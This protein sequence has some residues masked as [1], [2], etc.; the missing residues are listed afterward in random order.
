MKILVTDKNKVEHELEFQ[1]NKS[2]GETLFYSSIGVDIQPFAICGFECQC[3]TCHVIIDEEYFDKLLE[4]KDE[5]DYLLNTS[6]YREK[7][8]RLSC[9]VKMNENLDGMKVNIP[10]DF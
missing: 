6:L 9:Q 2:L 1:F 5:E 8:S 10:A 3:R 7:N 4:I